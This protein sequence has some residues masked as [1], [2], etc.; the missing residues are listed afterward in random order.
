MLDE[1][2]DMSCLSVCAKIQA[3]VCNTNTCVRAQRVTAFHALSFSNDSC[4]V[5][6]QNMPCFVEAEFLPPVGQGCRSLVQQGQ[7]CSAQQ[8]M[9]SKGNITNI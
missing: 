5:V 7:M 8:G 6:E 2:K 1:E 3:L 4:S 9:N